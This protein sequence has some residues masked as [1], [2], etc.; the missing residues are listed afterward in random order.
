MP[1]EIEN[2]VLARLNGEVL[3]AEEEQLFDDWYEQPGNP[4]RY[5][6]WQKLQAALYANAKAGDIS[7][8][9]AWQKLRLQK[10]F[11]LPLYRL[12]KYAAVL[13]LFIGASISVF[14]LNREKNPA[15][16][17]ARTEEV[18][19]GRKQAVLTLSTGKQILL[20]DTLSAIRHQEKGINI[21]QDNHILSYRLSGT[22]AEPASNTIDIPR[23]GEYVIALADGT[24]IWLNAESRITYP[25]A[26]TGN[27]REVSLEG[28]AYFEIARDTTKP[29]IVHT[30]RFDI[31][32]TGTQF[33]V[34]T[35]PEETAAATLTEGKIQLEREG[36]I[37][38]LIPGQQA[39][40][41]GEQVEIRDVDTEEAIAWRYESFSFKQRSLESILNEL[42][43]WYDV[44]I[45]YQ[46]PEVKDY[47]FTAWFRRSSSIEEV[48]RILEKTKKIN[49]QL[50]GKTLTVRSHSEK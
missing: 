12:M 8:D 3:S 37:S 29:F 27:T 13:L 15:S 41:V 35:Y 7:A 5:Y 18:L 24:K 26:F 17:L 34:R 22:T 50:K 9:Q 30:E 21:E 2:I 36:H 19:P 44:N 46:N 10:R 28:E 23:G 25:T 48:I 40:L 31:R 45:F 38:R 43:R 32:V 39:V 1:I 33:N 49:I 4:Q 11:S 20:S 47:H 16:L 14:L 42:A 6:E